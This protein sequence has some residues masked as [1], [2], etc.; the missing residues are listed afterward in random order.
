MELHKVKKMILSKI[1]IRAPSSPSLLKS[2][3]FIK[4]HTLIHWTITN[5]S[6]IWLYNKHIKTM[7]GQ[8]RA[9]QKASSWL[10]RT[11]VAS[12]IMV[13]MLR[14]LGIKWRLAIIYYHRLNR[15]KAMLTSCPNNMEA[16][17]IKH[18]IKEISSSNPLKSMIKRTLIAQRF[19]PWKI[20]RGWT[21]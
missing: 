8:C 6:R 20:T 17:S 14:S 3:S 2:T 4:M 5:R 15:A 16:W 13:M 1:K 12:I 9:K 21:S 10:T 11:M 18:L 7:L 19:S